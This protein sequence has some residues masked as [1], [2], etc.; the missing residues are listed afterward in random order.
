MQT[1]I[2]AIPVGK[3]WDII[4]NICDNTPETDWYRYREKVFYTCLFVRFPLLL[5]ADFDLPLLVLNTTFRG[6]G[7]TLGPSWC[8]PCG[9]L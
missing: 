4:T 3:Y 8:W 1:N 2:G 7:N 6:D 5:P 9:M